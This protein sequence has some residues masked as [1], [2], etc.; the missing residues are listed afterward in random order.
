[1]SYKNTTEYYSAI[2]Y[3]EILIFVTRVELEGVML[4]E[5][6]ETEK[7]KYYMISHVESRR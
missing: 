7:N 3:K 4:S 5:I 6:I 2:N 1:M